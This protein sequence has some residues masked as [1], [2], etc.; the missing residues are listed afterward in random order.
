MLAGLEFA[1]V[2]DHDTFAGLRSFQEQ[3]PVPLIPGIELTVLFQ[4][5][6]LH[7]VILEPRPRPAFRAILASLAHQREYR[8]RSLLD[9]LASWGL[10]L[11]TPID[12]HPGLTKRQVLERI[13]A[14]EANRETMARLDLVGPKSIKRLCVPEHVNLTA[15]GVPLQ[16]ALAACP[17]IHILAH[18]GASLDPEDPASDRLLAELVT[19]HPF[20]GVEVDTRRHS[21]A[22]RR[23]AA[24]IAERYGLVPITTND[25]HAE[26]ELFKNRTPREQLDRLYAGHGSARADWS[27]LLNEN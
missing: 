19:L 12:A 23:W 9:R 13:T 14:E 22:A 8:L 21:P 11:R 15:D 4:G 2:T 10:V 5:R 18:P 24:R 3:A 27:K 7:V 6:K 17:G 26:S 1:A 16:A 25:V 20:A